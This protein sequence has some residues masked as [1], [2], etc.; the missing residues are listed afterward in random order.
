MSRRYFTY[1]SIV[2]KGLFATPY[3]HI[4]MSLYYYQGSHYHRL[5]RAIIEVDIVW[6]GAIESHTLNGVQSTLTLAATSC[7]TADTSPDIAATQRAFSS[8]THY[9]NESRKWTT[10]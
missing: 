3:P 9:E 4:I 5:Y 2:L 6:Y 7:L 8:C 1:D 10:R